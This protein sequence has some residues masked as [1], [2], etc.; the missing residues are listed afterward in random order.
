MRYAINC[1]TQITYVKQMHQQALEDID[2]AHK[3]QKIIKK[4][5]EVC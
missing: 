2:R 5:R 4:L 3:M 1:E